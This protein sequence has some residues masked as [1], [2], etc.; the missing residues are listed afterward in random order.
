MPDLEHYHVDAL[1]LDAIQAIYDQSAYPFVRHVLGC[2]GNFFHEMDGI[3][4]ARGEGR[5][6]DL[7]Q[8]TSDV[9]VENDDEY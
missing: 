2:F 4:K 9:S 1:R 7:G 5:L 6:A 8:G 3:F